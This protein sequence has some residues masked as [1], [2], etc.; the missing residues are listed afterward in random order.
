MVRTVTALPS[1]TRTGND[2]PP[3][4]LGEQRG[5]LLDQIDALQAEVEQLKAEILRLNRVYVCESDGISREFSPELLAR[6]YSPK[7]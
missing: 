6:S 1:R 5:A 3:M 7:I 4:S 2:E